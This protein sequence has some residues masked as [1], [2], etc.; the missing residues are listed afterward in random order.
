M[1]IYRYEHPDTGDGPYNHG[2][3]FDFPHDEEL[4]EFQGRLGWEHRNRPALPALLG[5]NLSAE[6][7][8]GCKTRSQLSA[9]FSGFEKELEYFGFV[10]E[11]YDVPDEDVVV[12]RGQ[13]AFLLGAER[14]TPS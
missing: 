11:V 12:A 3:A 5:S 4:A 9:W 8:S 6:W 1:Q 13:V 10:V 14:L 2:R 7:R